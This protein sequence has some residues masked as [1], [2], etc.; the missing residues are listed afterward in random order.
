M[1]LVTLALAEHVHVALADGNFAS[2]LLEAADQ[3]GVEASAWVLLGWHLLGLLLLVLLG[4][5]L[6]LLLLGLAVA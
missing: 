2:V 1:G 4:S 6:L 5:C 3:I